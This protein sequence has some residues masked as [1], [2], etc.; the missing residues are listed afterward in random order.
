ME[1]DQQSQSVEVYCLRHSYT[2]CQQLLTVDVKWPL[3][4]CVKA[5]TLIVIWNLQAEEEAGI[6]KEEVQSSSYIR[7]LNNKFYFCE[8]N[9]LKS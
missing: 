1:F 4:M 3:E 8:W 2:C 7:L 5:V 6:P 9:Y